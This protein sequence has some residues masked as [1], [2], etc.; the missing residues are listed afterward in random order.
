MIGMRRNTTNHKLGSQD[1]ESHPKA[2]AYINLSRKRENP[3]GWAG[4]IT[5]RDKAEMNITTLACFR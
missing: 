4:L 5:A 1:V 2:N 3:G